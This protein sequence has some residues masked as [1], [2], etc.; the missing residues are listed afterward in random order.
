ML[1]DAGMSMQDVSSPQQW[2][3]GAA[4]GAGGV[5][6][7]TQSEMPGKLAAEP[8]A[9][10]AA[11]S[12]KA[13]PKPD[14]GAQNKAGIIPLFQ[15]TRKCKLLKASMLYMLYFK[16]LSLV[17]KRDETSEEQLPN[18]KPLLISPHPADRYET[19][20]SLKAYGLYNMWNT[21]MLHI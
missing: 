21:V 14:P 12:L 18:G 6:S 15:Q 7:S 5:V 11:T 20:V 16:N 4:E 2:G 19:E 10:G 9:P 3:P 8:A 13:V 1:C 17:F